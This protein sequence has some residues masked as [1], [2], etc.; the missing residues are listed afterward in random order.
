MGETMYEYTPPSKIL[1][2]PM[3]ALPEDEAEPVKSAPAPKLPTPPVEAKPAATASPSAQKKPSRQPSV[4]AYGMSNTAAKE[5]PAA[6]NN[7]TL[8]LILGASA[9]LFA[10]SILVVAILYIMGKI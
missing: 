1:E 9:V 7:R 5:T 4:V 3:V 6:N 8:H 2:A 10:L